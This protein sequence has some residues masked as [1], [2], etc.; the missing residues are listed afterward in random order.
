MANWLNKYEQGG[1]VLKKKT[2]DNF[3]KKANPND[4][5]AS[6]GPDFVGLG[7]N[8]KGRNYSPAW[9]GQFAMGGALPG[10]VGFTY[11]RV[12]GS[13]PSNGK[14]A[15]KT[16]A[17]AQNGQEMKYY[18]EGLDFKPK[19][20]A[21]YGKKLID[22]GN[23][24]GP[25][26]Q[27]IYEGD[28]SFFNPKDF[29]GIR[30]KVE[31]YMRSDT[32][33]NRLKNHVPD[34]Q[35]ARRV[36]DARAN[37]VGSVKLASPDRNTEIGFYGN[38]DDPTKQ[39]IP[40]IYKDHEIRYND[41]TTRSILAHELGHAVS[42]GM[43]HMKGYEKSGLVP[44]PGEVQAIIGGIKTND[45]IQN[46]P[47]A[48]HDDHFTTVGGTKNL[49]AAGETYGDLSGLR[50]ILNDSG[51]TKN[52]GDK[53]TPEMFKKALENPKTKNDP[54][55]KR[56][57]MKFSDEDIIKMNNSVAGNNSYKSNQAQSGGS[58]PPKN[59]TLKRIDDIKLNIQ[60]SQDAKTL[61][62]NEY[63]AKYK[64]T[65]FTDYKYWKDD[66]I[67]S[68]ENQVKTLEQRYNTF[69]A[70]QKAAEQAAIDLANKQ[71]AERLEK[72]TFVNEYSTKQSEFDKFKSDVASKYN[73]T[74]GEQIL[75]P[76]DAIVKRMVDEANK[77]IETGIG[78]DLPQLP[79]NE[80]TCINGVCEIA[81]TAGVDFSGMEGVTGVRKNPYT[82]KLIPQ[83]NAGWA[84]NDN[85]KKA[86]YNKLPEGEIPQ[87]GDLAQ[88]TDNG[89]IHHMELVLG[90]DKRG[91]NTYNNYQQTLT[92][93]PGA[94]KG[95]RDFNNTP[96]QMKGGVGVERTVYYRL[97]PSVEQKIYET[98]PEYSGKVKGKQQFES[99][100]D[101][102]KFNEYQDYINKQAGK[103][104]QYKDYLGKLPKG[105]NGLLMSFE[106]EK[107]R[108]DATRVAAP[109]R[110]LTKKEK[111]ENAKANKEV[112]KRTEERNQAIIEERKNRRE[113][114]GDV[115]VPG[116]FNISEKFR[117]FP[118]SVGGL[119]EM[120]D[121]Y[122]NP[123]FTVG[124]L[125]DALGESTAAKDPGAIA[126]TLA[127]TAGMGAL[128]FDPLGGAMKA[129]RFSKNAINNLGYRPQAAS[130]GDPF[131]V[132][133]NYFG[134]IG[135]LDDAAIAQQQALARPRQTALSQSSQSS[136]VP[137]QF[138]TDEELLAMNLR[139]AERYAPRASRLGRQRMA[140][141]DDMT[142]L[143][144][145][146]ALDP[147]E[148]YYQ[149]NPRPVTPRI[150]TEEELAT[151]RSQFPVDRE[152]QS[153]L[154]RAADDVLQRIRNRIDARQSQQI[155]P[156]PTVVPQAP[157]QSGGYEITD[158][159]LVD[160]ISEDDLVDRSMYNAPTPPPP[161]PTLSAGPKFGEEDFKIGRANP[162]R[163]EVIDATG[164]RFTQDVTDYSS[165][166]RLGI[167]QIKGPDGGYMQVKTRIN[168]NDPDAYLRVTDMT[169]RSEDEKIA[170]GQLQRIFSNL[171]NKVDM[172]RISTSM[173]SQP[174]T[175]AQV[176]RWAN[177]KRLTESF[178]DV[179]PAGRIE[180]RDVHLEQ[181]NPW[182]KDN[183]DAVFN[184]RT[185]ELYGDYL[186]QLKR[187]FPK[188]QRTAKNVSE[189]T[190]TPLPEPEMRIFDPMVSSE[191]TVTIDD[192]NSSFWKNR[193]DQTP[194]LRERVKI[195]APKYQFK[196]NW[197]NGGQIVDPMGQ[198]AHPGEI[199]T[200]P[201]NDITMK[202]VNYDVLG[203]SN[204]GDKKLMKPGKNYKFDGDYVTEYPKGG[205]LNK[206][207]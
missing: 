64:G 30:D 29:E 170:S 184:N 52:F 114:K 90:S 39:N 130:F 148:E 42:R 138:P 50:L 150:P 140:T 198:W 129:Q 70:K 59:S 10:A 80:M 16:K 26:M 160:L 174:L 19:S 23:Y 120:F 100:D 20:I 72:E 176:A 146:T 6:V 190:G 158:A 202:G 143:N 85:Y 182:H 111:E 22:F 122:I 7:Y 87:I 41:K 3:G 77:A 61:S 115:N 104:N 135:N 71:K 47:S 125:A 121:E 107:M 95:R 203:V 17:S 27:N 108:S 162:G 137:Y 179:Y 92:P 113:T 37:S 142:S 33:L 88:Y 151:V 181:L 147:I 40:Q 56:M 195:Y 106:P 68:W 134:G 65:P 75:S 43:T 154:Q 34:E 185:G 180:L 13:A 35:F 207:K 191:I 51:I 49:S 44:N 21:Q 206:Y 15:K 86:G 133:D 82:G 175:D 144:R 145:S 32:Y 123:A 204:T 194:S 153:N 118:E 199:T 159:D 54:V 156:E 99:S 81:S 14:Y 119:G 60:A 46:Y 141:P 1:M 201:S 67:P 161:Q 136:R 117:L 57:K 12:A 149:R 96:N 38:Y 157:R 200:I 63:E 101:F 177:D 11:A 94:G 205:W 139:E 48:A 112:K 8:T 197:K 98:N 131:K 110:P 192:L 124:A 183:Y 58:I 173:Y 164:N 69:L 31:N 165:N 66:H 18:Q 55:L 163:E 5:Q 132:G 186:T 171:P 93:T 79:G 193:F 152:V 155:I 128:G 84:A 9:G 196:K 28:V 172:E 168:P 188:I 78:Y 76:H 25:E 36:R 91:I 127:M 187:Q 73:Y 126:A 178:K 189:A 4:V 24:Q 97:D 167:Y 169:F 103:Y 102:K 116:S 109:I 105:Q 45:V 53:L 2:K 62:K 74:P 83:Y 166:E 89:K